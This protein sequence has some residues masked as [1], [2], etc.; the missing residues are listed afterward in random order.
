[1][2]QQAPS[3]P[4]AGPLLR[5]TRGLRWRT[6][7]ETALLLLGFSR[8]EQSS[9]LDMMAAANGGADPIRRA[10][11]LRHALDEQRHATMFRLRAFELAPTL[12]G[13]PRL[14]RADFERLFERLGEAG[15][16]AFVHMGERRGRARLTAFRD[17]LAAR[18]DHK[19]RALLDA[20]LVD[21][22][23]HD[24][25]T[26]E[27]LGALPNG[28]ALS[29]RV[30][31]WELGRAW[32]RTGA[33]LSGVVFELLMRLL[34]LLAAPLAFIEKRSAKPRGFVKASEEQR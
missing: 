29:R 23:E 10:Q 33:A 13:D 28:A 26:A 15:F 17:E 22:A 27:L 5:L 3:A 18:G 24:R 12:K 32:R 1:M 2:S 9:Y 19:T 25:Y 4:A 7:R 20:I 21:E 16:I 30:R 6:P 11:Y 8:A 14:V 34:Y 31:A